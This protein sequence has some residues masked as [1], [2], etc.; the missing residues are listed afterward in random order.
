MLAELGLS[1]AGELFDHLPKQA[2]VTELGIGPGAS[3]QQT[4]R[5]VQDSAFLNHPLSEY[6]SFLGAGSYRHYL[7]AAMKTI[8]SRSEFYTAYTPYQP[9]CSQGTLQAI[10]EFQSYICLLTGMDVANASLYDGA[11]ALAEAVLM[12]LRITG[13]EKVL[14][15]EA[16]HPEYRRVLT[17]YMQGAGYECRET[18][19]SQQGG[20]DTSALEK[21]VD[22]KTS[23]L[24]VQSPNFFGIIEDLDR[25][26]GIVHKQKIMLVCL[27]DPFALALL[28]EPAAAGADIACGDT[29]TVSVPVSFGGPG[30][31][32]LACRQEYLRQLPGR[33]VGRTTDGREK[34][35]YCLTLQTREQHIRRER[36]TSNICSNQSLNALATAVYLSLLGRDGLRRNAC[37]A[38]ALT[39][40]LQK[41]LSGIKKIQFPFAG[42][43]FHE[44]V[45]QIK[46]ASRLLPRIADRKC[47]AGLELSRFYPGLKD[48][49][50][51][52][53]TEMN[54]R[55]EIDEFVEV[56]KEELRKD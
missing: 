4:G 23:C 35:G 44:F 6:R 10:Y 15:S 29:Q 53:C 7:P 20:V 48:S 42:P 28:K 1:S 3:E 12:S 8:L 41:S 11:T 14:V 31:G 21:I 18:F 45:W 34:T 49:I 19:F 55:E 33:I 2:R 13:R 38:A 25:I 36:A 37:A 50:L 51:S 47:I 46:G 16:V 54:T 30:C 39:R 26:A 32:F 22:D 27:A 52:C 43:Y 56:L 40:Y 24:V 17:T 5:K 9:E